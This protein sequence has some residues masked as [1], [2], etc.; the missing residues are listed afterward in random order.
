MHINLLE[1]PLMVSWYSGDHH[2]SELLLCK[3]PDYRSFVV[4]K[5]KMILNC[6]MKL[7]LY[8][9]PSPKHLHMAQAKQDLLHMFVVVIA[10]T[11]SRFVHVVW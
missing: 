11:T 1:A 2:L 10:K 6:P 5:I 9:W 3:H 7:Q 4:C 8:T